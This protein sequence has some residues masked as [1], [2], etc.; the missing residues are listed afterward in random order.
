MLWHT[1][2]EGGIFLVRQVASRHCMADTVW[3]L[4]RVEA[5]SVGVAGEDN[6]SAISISP[7]PADNE[8]VL[9]L[10]EGMTAEVVLYGIDGRETWRKE[11]GNPYNTIAVQ[12][13]PSGI[14]VL[15]VVTP[16]GTVRKRLIKK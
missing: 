4:I 1:F 7:N 10:P 13:F 2:P 14:Y 5:P 15:K 16:Q 12:G 8:V 11:T 9:H 3:Q 6:L